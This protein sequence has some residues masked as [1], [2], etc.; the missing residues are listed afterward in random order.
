MSTELILYDTPEQYM[1][2]IGAGGAG[3]AGAAGAA[4]SNTPQQIT[5]VLLN[6]VAVLY[7]IIT[8]KKTKSTWNM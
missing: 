3:A 4:F 6:V 2:L 8:L 7:C 5:V 1:S